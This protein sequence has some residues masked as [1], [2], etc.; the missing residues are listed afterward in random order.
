[1]SSIMRRPARLTFALPLTTVLGCSA[2]LI[3]SGALPAPV[4]GE[5][6]TLESIAG[7]LACYVD[8]QA[9]ANHGPLLLVHSVNAAGSAYEVKPL[10]DHYRG[11]RRVYALELPGYG[12]SDRSDRVYT[13]RMMTD[14][15]LAATDEIRR[16]EN[17]DAIDALA[18]SLSSE[19]LARAASERP[20]AYRTLALVSPTGFDGRGPYRGPAGSSRGK[21]WLYRLFTMP[22]WRRGLFDVLTSR[23]S[24][25]FFLEKTWGGTH[26]DE[27]V[28]EYARLT[29]RHPGAHHVPYYFISGY[30]FGADITSVY[31]SLRQP[32]WMSHGVRGDFVDYR[33]KDALANRSNWHFTVFDSGALPHFEHPR[34][35]TAAYDAFLDAVG[36]ADG[37][38]AP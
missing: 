29:T 27:G 26:I 32:V 36:R 1:M 15:V 9:S 7:P 12:H 37:H 23:A 18:V 13:L 35:F 16:R 6:F 33:Y 20:A 19:F 22:L 25:R 10:Y 38:P 28:F 31:E 11:S 4:S 14:A 24:I 2:P 5:T 21:A 8:G 3:D 17:V 30:L 34:E